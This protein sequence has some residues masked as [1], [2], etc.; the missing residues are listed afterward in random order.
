MR[1]N[2]RLVYTNVFVDLIIDGVE[3][4]QKTIIIEIEQE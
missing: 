4:F 3:H 1:L 2:S